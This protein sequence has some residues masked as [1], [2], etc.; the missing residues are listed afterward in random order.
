MNSG[1]VCQKCTPF[2]RGVCQLCA[3]VDKGGGG[4]KNV[5]KCVYVFYGCPQGTITVFKNILKEPCIP[6]PY[7]SPPTRIL[8]QYFDIWKYFQVENPIIEVTYFLFFEL[9]QNLSGL[10]DKKLLRG[11]YQ[12]FMH[13][14]VFDDILFILLNLFFNEKTR[15]DTYIC[16]FVR[17]HGLNSNVKLL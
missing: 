2:I 14:C 3:F 6:Y 4:V 7:F 1:G 11:A 10:N 12:N 5:Q 17:H 16:T 15:L 8:V 9:I 13:F